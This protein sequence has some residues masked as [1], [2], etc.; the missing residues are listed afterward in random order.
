MLRTAKLSGVTRVIL[1]ER[2]N[3]KV[4]LKAQY[5]RK[6]DRSSCTPSSTLARESDESLLLPGRRFVRHYGNSVGDVIRACGQGFGDSG[7]TRGAVV[8]EPRHAAGARAR[9][10]PHPA[11]RV[12]QLGLPVPG[13]HGHRTM[14]SAVQRCFLMLPLQV[15]KKGQI[16]T[17]ICK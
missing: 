5:I 11:R 16:L 2:L 4:L 7:A 17:N 13:R 6:V 15:S 14:R 8:A 9:A 1:R 10:R 3:E 12:H